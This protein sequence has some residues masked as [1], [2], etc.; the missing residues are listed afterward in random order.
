MEKIISKSL[1][2]PG[3]TST[4]VR[5]SH[6]WGIERLLSVLAL[7]PFRCEECGI[8][9]KRFAFAARGTWQFHTR[10]SYFLPRTVQAV[11]YTA[12]ALLVLL[13]GQ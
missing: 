10:S 8:R 4:M 3:C 9:F 7:Y 2:C 13:T 1:R 5:R 12:H 11:T 6:R